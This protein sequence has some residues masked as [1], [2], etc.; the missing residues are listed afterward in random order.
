M[1][2]YFAKAWKTTSKMYLFSF[3]IS[4]LMHNYGITEQEAYRMLIERHKHYKH[5]RKENGR[6]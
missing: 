2:N 6:N 5:R 4:Q 3:V 1:E